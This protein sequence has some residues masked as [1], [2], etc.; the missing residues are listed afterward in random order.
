MSS[1]SVVR[2]LHLSDFHVGKDNYGQ[3]VLFRHLLK[4]IQER[5]AAGVGPDIVLITGDIA[6]K[7]KSDQYEKF[8]EEFYVPLWGLLPDAVRERII[9]IPG[10]HDVDRSQARAVQ[11]YDVLLRVPEFLDP[12]EQGAFE[13]R[14]ILPRLKAF[15]N[16]DYTSSGEH[17][18]QSSSGILQREIEIQGH[19]VGIIGLNTAWLACTD[20]DRHK[21][22]AGKSL[23]EEGL[24]ALEKCALTLVLGHHPLDWLLDTEREPMRALLGRHNALYLHGHCHKDGGRYEVG[25]GYPFLTLQAGAAFQ[26]REDEIWVNGLLWGEVDLAT[27]ELSV[28]PLQW[29]RDNQ[30]WRLDGTAFPE[31]FRRADRWVFPLP[32]PDTYKPHTDD[33]AIIPSGRLVP[34]SGWSE[35]DRHYLEERRA[36]LTPEQALSFF[37]GRAPIWREA[38]APQIPHRAIV[39]QL[40]ETLEAAR[41]ASGTGVTLLIG[42]AGEGKTTVLL[43]T[44]C[45]LVRSGQPWHILWRHNTEAT[46]PAE[47]LARLP[48]GQTWLVVSDDAETLAKRVFDALRELNAVGRRNLQFLLTCRDTDWRAVGADD[49]HWNDYAVFNRVPLHGLTLPDARRLVDAWSAYGREGLQQLVDLEAE[50]AAQRLATAA[51]TQTGSRDGAFL[52]ALLQMRLGDALRVRV[53]ELLEKLAERTVPGGRTL[54]QAFAYIAAAHAAEIS[55]LS[56]EVLA[57]VLDCP[58][59]NLKRHVLHPLGE[60]AA[61][62]TTGQFIF[63]RHSAIA[64]AAVDLLSSTFGVDLEEL[65]VDL[66]RAAHQAF[67]NGVYVPNFGDWQY[68]SNYFFVRGDEALGIRLAQVAVDEEPRNAY[69]IVKLAQ[70]LREAGQPELGLRA[71][72]QT[73]EDMER[74]R[75]YYH[76]WGTTAGNASKHALNTLLAGIS[77]CDQVERKPP[78]NDQAEFSLNGLSIAFAE[79]FDAYNDYCFIQACGAAA[80]LGLRLRLDP[81]TRERLQRSQVRARAAGVEDVAPHLA[82]QRVQQA[83][84]VAYAQR[85]DDLPD[86]IPTGDTLT[87]EGLARLLRLG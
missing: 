52:G 61:I 12:T 84:V 13:R 7:G 26:A 56:K 81:Q 85:E 28:E 82:L 74:I 35:I 9:I 32:N 33:L 34:P 58:Q 18:L 41:L 30:E 4:H 37:D 39:S 21:L 62:A 68:L 25:A 49:L 11:T 51:I 72:E 46:L 78:D 87:F 64:N 83:I 14:T 63:T 17:W 44:V 38:L 31:R 16:N 50:E 73:P 47:W 75:G 23:L 27:R 76:E 65:F 54:Q 60:E 48:A 66:V 2:W 45:D 59:K 36:E 55:S 22:S 67:H 24:N 42:A 71:F 1:D 5:V 86:Y 6:N 77:L 57:E 15:E 20:Q 80:Q 29:S 10:N 53:S 19:K 40:V 69:L 43:Q 3:R 70:L 8:C 79:L